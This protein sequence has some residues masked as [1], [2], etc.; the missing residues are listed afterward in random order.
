MNITF[1]Y[2]NNSDES[3]SGLHLHIGDFALEVTAETD[4]AEV[5]NALDDVVSQ[6]NNIKKEIEENY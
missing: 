6:L 4:K 1:S 5:L 2:I 3:F